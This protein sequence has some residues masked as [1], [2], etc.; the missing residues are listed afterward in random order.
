MLSTSIYFTEYC[1]YLSLPVR[2]LPQTAMFSSGSLYHKSW[3][4]L[5]IRI[6]FFTYGVAKSQTWLSNWTEMTD[7]YMTVCLGIKFW[8][9]CAFD[10]LE[11]KIF[12]I[13]L[14]SASMLRNP[15]SVCILFLF[16]SPPVSFW[17][18]YSFSSLFLVSIYPTLI[19][20]GISF[21]SVFCMPFESF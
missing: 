9:Q 8:V 2:I 6:F 14:S 10:T 15:M 4:T 17:N 1:R 5:V 12:F 13:H 18:L 20:P 19:S 21:P 16:R 11:K 7:I 3:N